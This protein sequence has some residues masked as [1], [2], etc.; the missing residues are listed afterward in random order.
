[1]ESSSTPLAI[2]SLDTIKHNLG[3]YNKSRKYKN[4]SSTL[5]KINNRKH[6]QSDRSPVFERESLHNITTEED[7]NLK[8]NNNF[9]NLYILKDED[10]SCTSQKDVLNYNANLT[11][12]DYQHG[13]NVE[14]ILPNTSMASITFLRND[15]LFLSEP[16]DTKKLDFTRRKNKLDRSSSRVFTVNH[17]LFN[18]D[19][20]S[21]Q[22]IML[23]V[24]FLLGSIQLTNACNEAICA[25]IVSK[26]TL[27]KSCE[28][29][30]T[31]DGCPCCKTCFM[32]LDYLQTDCCS[33]VGLCPRPN[34]TS[35]ITPQKSKIMDF[36]EAVPSLWN[37]LTEGDDDNDR[38]TLSKYPVDFTS[39]E[40]TPYQLNQLHKVN[41][42]NSVSPQ[43]EEN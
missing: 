37:A 13:S 15:T 1:M 42:I 33:C 31:A 24:L 11:Q 29:E 40:L 2:S 25:S 3:N 41:K 8:D 38:W 20:S 18:K 14:Q 28:C 17:F 35:I 36:P 4:S 9:S 32:C 34:N 7:C 23:F 5:R 22:Y 12:R 43:Q 16:Q 10:Y 39:S 26:C 21:L 30:I 27:L 6:I 19:Y